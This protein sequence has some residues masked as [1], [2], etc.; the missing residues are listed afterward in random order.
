[1]SRAKVT[2]TP[3]LLNGRQVGA[4]VTVEREDGKPRFGRCW[5]ADC[6]DMASEEGLTG[7]HLCT[8]HFDRFYSTESFP[9]DPERE[10]KT[11]VT[12]LPKEWVM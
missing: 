7:L 10:F 1:M 8:D 11:F 9:L 5:A 12:Y 6:P 4:S 3:V 2:R